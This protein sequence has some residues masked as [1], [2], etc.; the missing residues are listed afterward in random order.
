MYTVIVDLADPNAVRS[1]YS[2]P[3]RFRAQRGIIRT[4]AIVQTRDPLQWIRLDPGGVVMDVGCGAREWLVGLIQRTP[5][6]RA[7]LCDLN[8]PMLVRSRDDWTDAFQHKTQATLL[9]SIK[10]DAKV[11]PFADEAFHVVTALFV[12]QHVAQQGQF[13]AECARVTKPCGSF[14]VSGMSWWSSADLASEAA[15]RL[16]GMRSRVIVDYHFNPD[17][18]RRTVRPWFERTRF[19]RD[20]LRFSTSRVDE[21]V[22]LHSRLQPYLGAALPGPYTWQEYLEQYRNVATEYIAQHGALKARLDLVYLI[23]TRRK[24]GMI[25]DE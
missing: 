16:M 5:N 24:H 2:D 9:G 14:I 3:A 15:S 21:L 19:R 22:R 25:S 8:M 1:A 18:A 10:A 7:V 13:L 6:S 4:A 17:L 23:A 11:L 20:S 12:S